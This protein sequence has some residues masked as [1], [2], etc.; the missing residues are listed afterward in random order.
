MGQIEAFNVGKQVR[1]RPSRQSTASEIFLPS[2]ERLASAYPELAE[3]LELIH[4]ITGEQV[5][6]GDRDTN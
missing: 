2:L 5:V 1:Y 6:L 3:D 4:P